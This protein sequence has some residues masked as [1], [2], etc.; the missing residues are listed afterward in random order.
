MDDHGSRIK[1]ILGVCD[2]GVFPQTEQ[3][4]VRLMNPPEAAPPDVACCTLLGLLEFER[5]PDAAIAVR[6][7]SVCLEEM[8]DCSGPSCQRPEVDGELTRTA[9]QSCH[10]KKG[11]C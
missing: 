9:S 8:C 4:P 10:R 6:Q 2:G 1:R 7:W 5:S 3:V 11:D